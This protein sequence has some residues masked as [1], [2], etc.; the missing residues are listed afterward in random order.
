MDSTTIVCIKVMVNKA[1][2]TFQTFHVTTSISHVQ[3]K[4]K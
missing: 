4:A 1:S 2:H 3:L